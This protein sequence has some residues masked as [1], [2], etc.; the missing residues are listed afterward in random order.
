MMNDGPE[1]SDVLIIYVY[2]I[3]QLVTGREKSGKL[4]LHEVLA[5]S[6]ILKLENADEV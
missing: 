3:P 2:K 5:G 6:S 4:V 1:R